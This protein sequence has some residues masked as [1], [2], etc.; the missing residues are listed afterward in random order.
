MHPSHTRETIYRDADG[1]ILYSIV[2]R[3][4]EIFGGSAD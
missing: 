1:N 4:E 2:Q 3:F